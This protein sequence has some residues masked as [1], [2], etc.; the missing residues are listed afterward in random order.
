MLFFKDQQQPC[1]WS[2][3]TFER[4]CPKNLEIHLW[5][6]IFSCSKLLKVCHIFIRLWI[7]TWNF[8]VLTASNHPVHIVTKNNVLSPSALIPFCDFGGNMSAMGVNIDQFDGPVCNS[9]QPRILNDQ[10]CYEVNLHNIVR[11]KK[12]DVYWL[13]LRD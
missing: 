3:L 4:S 2:M 8:S 6:M 11:E 9:F 5:L 1:P 12:I 13:S 10:H 7:F